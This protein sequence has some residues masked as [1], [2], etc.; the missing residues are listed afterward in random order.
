MG[1]IIYLQN[2]LDTQFF[3]FIALF[4]N[5]RYVQ[6]RFKIKFQELLNEVN[7]SY[8]SLLYKICPLVKPAEMFCKGL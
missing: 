3:I 8:N 1:F 6:N 2:V 4:T 5:K 7:S